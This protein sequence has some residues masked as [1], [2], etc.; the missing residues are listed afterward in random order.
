MTPT[1]TK[2]LEHLEWAVESRARNQRCS[3]RLLR[4]FIEFEEQWKTQRWAR[5]AQDLLSVS[6]SLWR[7]AFLADKTAKRTAVF[8]HATDFLEKIIEDN[9]ISYLQ[10]RKCN[11]WTFNYYTRNAR[12]ALETLSK[13]WPKQVSAYAGKKRTPTERWQYCQEL[14]DAAVNN[15]EVAA[16]TIRA[17]NTS[18]RQAKETRLAAKARRRKVREI[19]FAGRKAKN[20]A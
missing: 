17:K 1:Q 11:E 7:A 13:Y 5:A 2:K 15:F 8:S 10:D 18:G 9:A 20:E 16:R 6:F 4:L 12:A 14:L 19:T 3:V